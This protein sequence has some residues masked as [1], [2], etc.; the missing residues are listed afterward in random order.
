M[1]HGAGFWFINNWLGCIASFSWRLA[2]EGGKH[3]RRPASKPTLRA[4][5]P[6]GVGV[7]DNWVGGM[8]GGAQIRRI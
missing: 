3:L 5:P 2:A 6:C 8:R 4:A 1:E 7:E